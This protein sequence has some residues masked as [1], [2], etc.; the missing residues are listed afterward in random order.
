MTTDFK[1]T[2]VDTALFIYLSENNID[3]ADLSENFF[4]FCINKNIILKTSIITHLEFCV[5][6]YRENKLEFIQKFEAFIEKAKIQVNQVITKNDCDLASKLRAKYIG[7]KNFD[8]LQI[9]IAIKEKTDI[10]MTNDKKL[11][12]ITEISVFTIDEWNTI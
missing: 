10:F 12:N 3:F 7:L 2:F 8:A 6:P 4:N 1:S 11:K 9:A 5:K